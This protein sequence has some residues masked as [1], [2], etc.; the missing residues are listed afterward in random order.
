MSISTRRGDGGETSLAGGLRV[1]KAHL[2]VEAYGTV[3]ELNSAL[4]LARA[5]CSHDDLRQ[6]IRAIQEQ[7]FRIGSALATPPASRKPQVDIGP[8]LVDELTRQVHEIE[9]QEGILSDWSIPGEHTAAAALDLA[10]TICRR[11]ERQ[12]VRLREAGEPVQETILA[13]MNRLSDLLWLYGRKLE[14]EAGVDSS[15]RHRTQ[16]P[17][18]RWSRAW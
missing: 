14:S 11:A 18:P 15:L 17:G 5:L 8:E 1:S 2:R 16:R 4:G 13:Y 6:R 10:R 12:I 3:D 7:L 9:Q